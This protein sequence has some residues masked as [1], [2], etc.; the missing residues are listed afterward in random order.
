MVLDT[1]FKTIA[2]IDLYESFI[3]TDRYC[4]YGDFEIYMAMSV[5][6]LEYLKQD[7]YLINRNSEHVM[8]IEKI[9]IS[10]D[11]EDGG[12]ITVTG[13]SLE[14]ILDRRIIWGQ[15]TL[16][17][18]FQNGI[19]ILLNE[20]II[21]PLDN[22]RGIPNFIFEESSDPTITSLKIEAQ[23]TGDNLYD[24]ISKSCSERN[25]GFKITLNSQNQFVFKLYAGVDRSYDQTKNP[26]V[27]FSPKF[28]NILNSNYME[29]KS[30]LKNVTLI[31]GEGEGSERKYT[32]VGNSIGLERRELF[33]D[34][35]DISSDVGDGKITASE[36]YIAQLQQRGKEKLAENI[37][38]ISFEGKAETNL[39]YKL[40]EDFLIGD[41]V[42]ISNEYGHDGRARILEIVF[43]EDES[44]YS[45]YPT[46]ET[47]KESDE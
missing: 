6:Y 26:Y 14:S 11:I 27:I 18:N 34:A 24:T 44:G 38:V 40:G 9:R 35:R 3:W 21:S 10:S 17:G 39:M 37:A 32:S 7:Y 22:N 28:D 8:I 19:R 4:K 20:N 5:E 42:Q 43:S 23:Y 31:G 1:G 45:V 29:S 16:S 12:H 41:I 47:V 25:I 33:T 46:F 13:R 36:E 30:S 15:K 2:V